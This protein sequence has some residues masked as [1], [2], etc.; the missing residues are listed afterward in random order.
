MNREVYFEIR[1]V[2]AYLK[3]TAIDSLT[4]TEVSVV[5]PATGSHAQLKATAMR[6]LRYVLDKQ[7]SPGGGKP[8][9]EV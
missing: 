3:V 8:G 9:I 5:G 4:G 7:S 2:G 1:R 6:K